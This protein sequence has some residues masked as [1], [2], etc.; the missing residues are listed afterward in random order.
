MLKVG[1]HL[2]HVAHVGGEG[3]SA[4]LM[5]HALQVPNDSLEEREGGGGR[6][7]EGREGERGRERERK[8][9]KGKV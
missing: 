7:R 1:E 5:T 3:E 4:L 6:E 8:G 2:H 9:E